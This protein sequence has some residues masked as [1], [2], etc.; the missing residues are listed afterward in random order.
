MKNKLYIIFF[1]TIGLLSSCGDKFKPIIELELPKEAPKLVLIANLMVGDDSIVTYITRTRGTLD[2][3]PYPIV[4]DSI[5]Y[6]LPNDTTTYWYYRSVQLD[7]VSNAKV[8]LFKNSTLIATL[9]SKKSASLYYARLPAP[10]KSSETYT[11]R[12]SVPGYTTIES[13]QKAPKVVKIDSLIIKEQV[14]VNTPNSPLDFSVYDEYGIKFKDAIDESSCYFANGTIS[15]TIAQKTESQSLDFY[16]YDFASQNNLL[17]DASTNGQEII[18]RQHA[19]NSLANF[20]E[21]EAKD[22]VVTIDFINFT[23]DRYKYNQAYSRYSN[24]ANSPFAEPS[25]LFSNIKNGYGIFTIGAKYTG[26]FKV[27]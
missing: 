22:M 4:K 25:T 12:V 7:T 13:T 27:K 14:K 6:K 18:W 24:T 9:S 16:S 23:L 21:Q 15:Y 11:I 5:S 26:T 8:E 20:R 2:N 10:I 3:S 19:K 1:I 17:S